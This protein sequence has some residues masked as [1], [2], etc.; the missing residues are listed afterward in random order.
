MAFKLHDTLPTASHNKVYRQLKLYI[1][2]YCKFNYTYFYC[3]YYYFY[4]FR[5]KPN[6]QQLLLFHNND[7]VIQKEI[8]LMC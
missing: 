8:I 3:L 7:Y 4:L 2:L 5:S 6:F 1:K